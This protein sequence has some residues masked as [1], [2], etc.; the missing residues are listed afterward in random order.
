METKLKLIKGGVMALTPEQIEEIEREKQLVVDESTNDNLNQDAE[1]NAIVNVDESSQQLQVKLN[2]TMTGLMNEVVEN[3]KEDM[4]ALT[5]N[6]FKSELEIRET[7]VK[8][9]KNKEKAKVEKEVTEAQIEE[10]EAKH[11]RAKTILKAQG[12]TSQ[13]PKLFRV[14]AL[15]FGY[16]FFILYLLTVGW[17]VEFLTFTVKGFI[18]M[19][20]DCVERFTSVNQKIIENSNNKDFKLSRAIVNILKWVLIVGAI[21]AII[22]ILLVRK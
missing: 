6:A 19:V 20:A 15:V 2:D 17:I 14:T 9:R 3:H 18:T 22:I 10:D 12:L 1:E 13:L 4:L 21:A 7:Q 5:D 8:G 16:P 11:E